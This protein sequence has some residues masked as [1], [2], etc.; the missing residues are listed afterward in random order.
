MKVSIRNQ[1]RYDHCYSLYSFSN[2][3]S[4]E[5]HIFISA[6]LNIWKSL[7]KYWFKWPIGTDTFFVLFSLGF[8]CLICYVFSAP[9]LRGSDIKTRFILVFVFVSGYGLIPIPIRDTKRVGLRSDTSNMCRKRS[10]STFVLHVLVI[11]DS[12]MFKQTFLKLRKIT[13]FYRTPFRF[14]CILRLLYQ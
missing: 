10:T 7:E 2:L 13:F 12:G 4:N 11:V 6:H 3:T 9:V 14:S 5:D 1:Q 8:F